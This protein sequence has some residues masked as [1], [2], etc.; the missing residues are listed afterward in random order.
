MK[1]TVSAA[2]E[3]LSSFFDAATFVELGA[4]IRRPGNENENE[5]VVCGYGAVGGRLV[6]AFAQDESAMKGAVDGRHAEKIAML[7]EKA[8]SVGA[9]VV[10]MFDSAGAVVFDGAAALSGYGVLLDTVAS[11]AGVVPQIALV[12]GK[13]VG[14]MA[15][16]A[17]LFDFTVVT[18]GASLYV[19]NEESNAAKAA[20]LT[21]ANEADA[22]G[23]VKTLLSYLPDDNCSAAEAAVTGDD[24]NRAVALGAKATAEAALA[25]VVDSGLFLEVYGGYAT[26]A[27]I[28][29]ATLG[30]QPC[31]IA[32]V[33]GKLSAKGAEKLTKMIRFADAYS[34]SLVTLVNCSGV[35]T[36][37][38]DVKLAKALAKL[39]RAQS[40]SESA[41]V[42]VIVGE[43]V[44]AGFI[45]GGSKALGADV[46]FALPEAEIAALP[47]STAVAFL[48]NDRITSTTDRATVEKEWREKNATALAAASVG[49]VDDII[50]PAELRARIIAALYMLEGKN[51]R[52]L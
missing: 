51:G 9:P 39:A 14:T 4:Y 42:T 52:I 35:D 3:R 36:N 38:C 8:V 1:K 19:A 49:A 30:D 17:S 26:E 48:E 5:G 44:G 16:I 41:R 10:G 21:A 45:F 12:H 40:E 7:Y 32:A 43:A 18:E 46:V 25:A 37:G 34:M 28:G 13:C 23:K 22:F 20:A 29:F 50:D 11:A 27:K 31:V 47:A 2:R 6:F 15:A 24:P 33:D